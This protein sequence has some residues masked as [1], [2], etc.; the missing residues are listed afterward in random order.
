M[1]T[2]TNR[3]QRRTTM[4]RTIITLTLALAL[5]GCSGFQHRWDVYYEPALK[6]LLGIAVKGLE[7][8]VE[9]GDNAEDCLEH[10][11]FGSD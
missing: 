2:T 1:Q 9:H 6:T 7:E 8:C 11:E 10:V 5:A 3:N 4:K